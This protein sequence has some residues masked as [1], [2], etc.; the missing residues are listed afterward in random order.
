MTL[1]REHRLRATGAWTPAPL[2]NDRA[3]SVVSH[4]VEDMFRSH[5]TRLRPPFLSRPGETLR[6]RGPVAPVPEPYDAHDDEAGLA[7]DVTS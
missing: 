4:K 3:L 2:H 1:S 5:C 7:T 6:A